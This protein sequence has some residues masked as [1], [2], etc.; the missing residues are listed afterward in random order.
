MGFL[1]ALAAEFRLGGNPDQIAICNKR[2]PT[3]LVSRS[4]LVGEKEEIRVGLDPL[5]SDQVL[6]A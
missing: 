4:D 3:M 5:T 2:I 6:I 1:D